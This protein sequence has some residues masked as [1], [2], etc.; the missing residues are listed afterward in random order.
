MLTI[1]LEDY[2]AEEI[3]TE[4]PYEITK[5]GLDFIFDWIRFRNDVSDMTDEFDVDAQVAMLVGMM[6]PAYYEA[7][8]WTMPGE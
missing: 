4:G 2:M 6:L 5:E 8:G 7:A 3:G 1:L